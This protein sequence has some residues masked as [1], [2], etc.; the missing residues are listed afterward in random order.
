[1]FFFFLL[2]LAPTVFADSVWET[3]PN[4]ELADKVEND[5][6][7]PVWGGVWDEKDNPST[8][9]LDSDLNPLESLLKVPDEKRIEEKSELEIVD[10]YDPFLEEEKMSHTPFFNV[11][12]FFFFKKWVI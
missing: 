7:S 1:M 11:V 6:K 10:F 9:T 2:L 12:H 5:F 8:E 3:F 4:L